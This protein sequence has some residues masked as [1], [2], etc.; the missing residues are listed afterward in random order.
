MDEIAASLPRF[1][2]ALV[3]ASALAPRAVAI[4]RQLDH[5]VYDCLYLALAEAEQASLVTADIQLL[6]KVRATSW[7]PWAID[8]SAYNTGS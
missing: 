5:S 6:G 3:S 4:A 1:F 8:L 2:D 7:E